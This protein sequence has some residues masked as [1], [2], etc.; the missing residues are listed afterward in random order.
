MLRKFLVHVP[1][2]NRLGALGGRTLRAFA[3]AQI[4][5]AMVV[6]A[7]AACAANASASFDELLNTTIPDTSLII[8]VLVDLRPVAPCFGSATARSAC[9]LSR[10]LVTILQ[11]MGKRPVSAAYLR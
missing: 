6:R 7:N 5:D 8:F 4:I 1:R 3:G 10:P 9:R 11:C 2:G